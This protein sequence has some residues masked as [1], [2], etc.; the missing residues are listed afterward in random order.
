M[1]DIGGKTSLSQGFLRDFTDRSDLRIYDCS[2]QECEPGHAWGPGVRDHYLIHFILAGCGI[3]QSE[4]QTRSLAAGQGFLICPEQTAFY[5]ADQENPWHYVWIGFNGSRAA[6]YL[7]LAGLSVRSPV[8]GQPGLPDGSAA[9]GCFTAM[10]AALAQKRGRDLHLLGQLHLLLAGLAEENT[11]PPADEDQLSRRE[12]Y[13]RQAADFLA[14]NYSRQI[15][16][17]GLARQIGLDRSYFGVLFREQ[18]GVSPQQYLLRLRMEK[19][20]GLLARSSLPV[21]TVARSVG[22]EDPLL[23]SRMFR[24]VRG[25]TPSEYRS[26]TSP[27]DNKKMLVLG[28]NLEVSASE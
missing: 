5:Q 12:W 15:S 20:A 16:I 17:N 9:R 25:Q 24:K 10:A 27:A 22:Y 7:H 21:S 14:M 11:T 18:A 6:E 19:A 26:R 8:F 2:Q 1:L 23:F 13:V 4:G 28:E 3:F